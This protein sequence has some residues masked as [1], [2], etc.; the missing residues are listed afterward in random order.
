MSAMHVQATVAV[1]HA[2]RDGFDIETFPSDI[3]AAKQLLRRHMAHAKPGLDEVVF[4]TMKLE[5]STLLN[6]L[7]AQ[8]F[9]GASE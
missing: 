1:S 8:Y 2:R 9:E 6:E 3:E 4:A 7:H 5:L